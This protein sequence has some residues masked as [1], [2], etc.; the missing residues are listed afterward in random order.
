MQLLSF[1]VLLDQVGEKERWK[2]GDKK[3]DVLAFVLRALRVGE[4]KIK[5]QKE[6]EKER[7]R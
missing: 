5:I 3:R 4:R 1:R 6:K 7:E 2:R